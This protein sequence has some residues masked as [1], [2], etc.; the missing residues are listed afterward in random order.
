MLA[1]GAR[2]WYVPTKLFAF[3]RIH[4]RVCVC[5]TVYRIPAQGEADLTEDEDVV[6]FKL[7]STDDLDDFGID[8]VIRRIRARIKD[9]PV[10]L[11]QA[12]LGTRITYCIATYDRFRCPAS[13]SM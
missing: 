8:E 2:C 13:T 3:L 12:W 7:I 9:S 11:R 10:Y 1:S 5:I 6:G 4:A